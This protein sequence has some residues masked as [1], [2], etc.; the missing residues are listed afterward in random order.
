MIR[1]RV[2]SRHRAMSTGRGPSALAVASRRSWCGSARLRDALAESW[3]AAREALHKVAPRFAFTRLVAVVAAAERATRI[4]REHAARIPPDATAAAVAA[5]LGSEEIV[6]VERVAG[7]D[8]MA[9]AIRALN[10]PASR[11]RHQTILTCDARVTVT[12]GGIGSP[13]ASASI[14]AFASS[15]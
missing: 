9:A 6:A 3:V 12:P 11:A 4:Q 14:T 8:A 7:H 15:L 5:L 10:P 1:T 2:P 13:N